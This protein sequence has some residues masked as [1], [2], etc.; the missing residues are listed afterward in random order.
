MTRLVLTI[1]ARDWVAANKAVTI[2]K[3]ASSRGRKALK[4]FLPEYNG[5]VISDR[6]AVYNCFD[7][8][9]RQICLAHLRRDF[10]RFAYSKH[11]ELARVGKDLLDT[12]DTVFK[13]HKL[14]KTIEENKYLRLMSK[15]RERMLYYLKTVLEMSK[16]KQAQK[17]AR[18]ILKSFDM[19]WLFLENEDVEPTNNFAERQIKHHVKYRKNSFFT[20]SMRGDRFLERIKSLFAS[21]KLQKLNS[22]LELRNQLP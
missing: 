3:L 17:V 22:F 14:N 18:N 15:V 9:N 11:F 7:T 8:K 4:D 10:K 13:L 20:W 12:I 5:K 16:C 6:Y 2:F 1:K 21:S 19:M